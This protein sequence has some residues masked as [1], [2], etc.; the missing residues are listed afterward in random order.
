MRNLIQ[1]NNTKTW[2]A[3][4]ILWLLFQER[5]ILLFSP[6]A[7]ARKNVLDSWVASTAAALIVSNSGAAAH[8]SE[9]VG[10]RRPHRARHTTATGCG[11]FWPA[12]TSRVGSAPGPLV[13]VNRWP[14]STEQEPDLAPVPCVSTAWAPAADARTR[15]FPGTISIVGLASE[16]STS[17][18]RGRGL[19]LL[20]HDMFRTTAERF[21]INLSEGKKCAGGPMWRNT[22]AL[23]VTDASSLEVT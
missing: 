4:V 22:L 20:W 9:S 3:Q 11:S 8:V 23:N 10:S 6:P 2:R 15:C 21:L 16:V 13:Q 19:G 5:R 14:I 17:Y 12:D 1:A 18:V 7:A